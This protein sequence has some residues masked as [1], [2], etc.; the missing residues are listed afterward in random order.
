[1]ESIPICVKTLSQR[2]MQREKVN[3]LDSE[4]LGKILTDCQW[5]TPPETQLLLQRARQESC[6]LEELLI[7]EGTFERTDL[8]QLLESHYFCPSIDLESEGAYDPRS[9]TLLPRRLAEDRLALPLTLAAEG[10]TVALAEPDDQRTRD[11]LAATAQCNIIPV[12]ALPSALKRAIPTFYDRLADEGSSAEQ[13]A[14]SSPRAKRASKGSS[15][16]ESL[17]DCRKK[18]SPAIVD[19]LIDVAARKGISDIHIQPQEKEWLVRY[20]LDGILHT[21]AKIPAELEKAV[22]ARLKILSDLNIAEHRLTQDGRASYRVGAEYVDLRISVLPS[23]FGEKVV[24]RL[25]AKDANL[26]RLEKLQL[27]PA[28]RRDIDEWIARPQGLFLVTG[29]TGSGKTTTLY[30]VLNSIDCERLNVITLE[31]PIEYSF[32]SM[33]QV[34]IRSNIGMTF[35][36]GLR[37][38]LRQDPDV[39]LVGELRDLETAE[40]ACR[41]ALTGHKVFSTLHTNDTVQAITRLSSMGT[42]TYLIAATLRGVLAQRLVRVICEDCKEPYEPNNAELALLRHVD[43]EQLFRGAGCDRCASSGYRGRIGVFELF[44][45][46]ENIHRLICDRAAPN[47]IKQTAVRNGMIRMVESCKQLVLVGK[48]TVAE[49]QRVV[50]A[51][52]TEEQLCGNCQRAVSIEYSVCPFCQH[53]LREKCPGCGNELDVGWE[54]CPSCGHAIER[55]WNKTFCRHCLAPVEKEWRSCHFCG[56]DLE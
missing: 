6:F 22:V 17:V 42:P 8:L 3:P 38:A 18:D 21:V 10:L 15:M 9:L 5:L 30:A 54:A 37:S 45:I 16:I 53:A 26:V 46:D 2:R 20:R 33:T 43:V 55:E 19:H 32:P 13:R 29:P 25:L 41:A 40:T 23:Q 48:T 44:K 28:L 49:M 24:I 34:Q 14:P 35:A 47:V 27:P 39:I 1:M 56:G 11:A 51:D 36:S 7:R 50:L 12:V 52:E 31:D 4:V